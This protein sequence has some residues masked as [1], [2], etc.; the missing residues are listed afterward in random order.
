[1][2]CKRLAVLLIFGALALT[3]QADNHVRSFGA[4][5]LSSGTESWRA[6][7]R[8]PLLCRQGWYIPWQPPGKPQCCNSTRGA[9]ASYMG[10][11]NCNDPDEEGNYAP[12]Y[13][14]KADTCTCEG[15]GNDGFCA[16]CC[17][18]NVTAYPPTSFMATLGGDIA[19]DFGGEN[20]LEAN[21]VCFPENAQV[22]GQNGQKIR[23]KDLTVGTKIIGPKGP[24]E[25]VT[26]FIH[27]DES[28]DGAY[29]RLKTSRGALELS[30]NHLVFLRSAGTRRAVLAHTVR[31]G[32]VLAHRDG[33]ATVMAI[34]PFVARGAYA[35]L[36]MSGELE[37]DG[38]SASC[39]AEFPSH[40][41][42]H[43]VMKPLN[44]LPAN[45][46]GIH[47]YPNAWH[48]VY[49]AAKKMLGNF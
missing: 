23:M 6:D 29:L 9:P 12:S 16:T 36:T 44:Y 7:A 3:A 26:N 2:A 8:C 14:A 10:V 33:D 13:D 31:L 37:V 25:T 20:L 45:Q 28:V 47:W 30:T 41:A 18:A 48:H 49:T 38:F 43:A 11:S 32:D 15:N 39:Y 27:R 19:V 21:L 17:D 5:E 34:E 46:G 24:V 22:R 4:T 1:M 42:A 40:A 35:P